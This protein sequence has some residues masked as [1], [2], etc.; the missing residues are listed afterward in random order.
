MER[1]LAMQYSLGSHHAAATIVWDTPFT[2][3]DLLFPRCLQAM[4]IPTGIFPAGR[5]FGD[6]MDAAEKEQEDHRV[7]DH[8]RSARN[9]DCPPRDVVAFSG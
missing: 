5:S 7:D 8:R 1:S 6:N 4:R 9:F 2:D 3:D